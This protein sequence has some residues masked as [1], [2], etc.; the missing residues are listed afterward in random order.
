MLKDKTQQADALIEELKINAQLRLRMLKLKSILKISRISADLITNTIT[1]VCILL[2]FLFSTFTLG[3]YFSHLFKSY[4][5]GFGALTLFYISIA[6][7]VG[8]LKNNMLEKA[9]MD[10]TIGKYFKKYH[11]GNEEKP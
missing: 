9:L 5:L 1:I 6:L 11:E 4:F 8:A 3:W 10:F 7:I 2:A